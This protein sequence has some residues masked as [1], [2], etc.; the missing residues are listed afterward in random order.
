[1]LSRGSCVTRYPIDRGRSHI[2]LTYERSLAGEL[3]RERSG[4]IGEALRK[5]EI[6]RTQRIL[7]LSN[8]ALGTVVLRPRVGFEGAIIDAPEIG[9]GVYQLR[10]HGALEVG[11]GVGRDR[12]Q[13]GRR[14]LWRFVGRLRRFG[15]RRRRAAWVGF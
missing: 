5:N 2:V 14:R 10:T 8:E 12:L 11:L 1:M 13:R 15:L 3:S 4:F 9:R 7:G 6:L